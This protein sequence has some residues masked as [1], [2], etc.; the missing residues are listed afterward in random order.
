MW[1]RTDEEKARKRNC[2]FC[3]FKRR[4]DAEDAKNDL[5]DYDLDGYKMILGWFF[6]IFK[7]MIVLVIY[8]WAVL[9]YLYLLLFVC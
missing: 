2:G 3:S 7:W 6:F 9:L 4:C 1:P 8:C 5:Q